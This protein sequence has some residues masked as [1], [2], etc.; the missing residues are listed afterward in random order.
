MDVRSKQSSLLYIIDNMESATDADL[1]KLAETIT[2]TLRRK[3][4][5]GAVSDKT[6]A[7]STIREKRYFTWALLDIRIS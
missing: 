2:P 1:F 7:I 3:T 6:D 5:G 4:I